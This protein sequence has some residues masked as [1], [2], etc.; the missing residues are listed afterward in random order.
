[1]CRYDR[2][3]QYFRSCV[4]V[5]RITGEIANRQI[6]IVPAKFQFFVATVL[7]FMRD[8]TRLLSYETNK[9]QYRRHCVRSS[10]TTMETGSV[11]GFHINFD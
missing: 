9:T 6:I 10:R 5:A 3:V 1:M 4:Q 7:V 11:S 8:S 2:S